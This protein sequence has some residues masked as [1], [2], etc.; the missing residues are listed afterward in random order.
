[1]T[2]NSKPVSRLISRDFNLRFGVKV[3]L[4][5]VAGLLA[6]AEALYRYTSYELGSSYREAFYTMY[7]LKVGIFPLIFASYYTAA[8]LGLVTF[9]TAVISVIFSHRIAGPIYR[10]EKGMEAI[11]SGDL[12]VDTRFRGADALAPLADEL[13]AMTRTLNHRARGASDA[14]ED[15]GRAEE[16]LRALMNEEHP[17]EEELTRAVEEL[18]AG[19]EELKR[20]T[21]PVKVKE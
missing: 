6:F 1:M 2:N 18:R 16:R 3:L 11:G 4:I 10:L 21:G 13:N 14:A 20:V 5:T 15:I 19:V 17:P 8:I 12:T 7:H 9:A